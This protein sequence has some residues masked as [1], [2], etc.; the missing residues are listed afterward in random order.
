M[1]EDSKNYCRVVFELL[2]VGSD[3]GKTHVLLCR[4]HSSLEK[5]SSVS[6]PVN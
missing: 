4:K 1:N 6:Y 5:F 2:S 3:L